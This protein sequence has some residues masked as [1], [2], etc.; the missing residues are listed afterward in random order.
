MLFDQEEIILWDTEFAFWIGYMPRNFDIE[1]KQF[2]EI[3]QMGA[4]RVNTRSYD[5]T[6]ELILH[7]KPTV[8]PVLSDHIIKLTGITQTDADNG[9][10]FI[11]AL[12]KF[13][14][15]KGKLHSYSYKY[16]YAIL[17]GNILLKGIDIP[18]PWRPA[19]S[20]MQF[21]DIRDIFFAHDIPAY[22]YS[23]GSIGTHFGLEAKN[24]HDALCD[25]KAVVAALKAL[26]DSLRQ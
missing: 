10:D 14:H 20:A 11:D 25:T 13:I 12:E 26:N 6:D 21:F 16:D 15:F 4:V 24:K 9:C 19:L 18:E 17:A 1:K 2:T 22:K 7:V 5:V 8:N 3:I 23:S